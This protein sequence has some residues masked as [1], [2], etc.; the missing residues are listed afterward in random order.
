[1][2]IKPLTTLIFDLDGTLCRY[3]ESLEDALLKTFDLKDPEDLPLT[4]TNYQEGFGVEFDRAIDGEV[5]R[6]DLDFR[7]RVFWNLLQDDDSFDSSEVISFGEKF[8]KIRENSLTLF[9]DVPPVFEELTGKFKL[10]LLTN[11]PS[12]LQGRKIEKLGIESWFDSI[13]I[14]GQHSM[15]KPDP[16]IFDIAMEKLNSGREETIYI[17]NSLKYDVL[18]ANKAKLPVIWRKDGEEEEVEGAIP[19][20]VINEL[21]ELIEGKITLSFAEHGKRRIKL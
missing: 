5:E 21:T 1:M 18:G 12:S 7:T 15:A 2:E 10:G 8:T 9:D 16:R 14:S 11:G 19:N 13:T 17:G 4:P 20:L 6:Q 3:E